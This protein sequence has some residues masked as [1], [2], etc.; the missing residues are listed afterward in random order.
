[1]VIS[2]ENKRK[3][4]TDF[5]SMWGRDFSV[6]AVQRWNE[7]SWEVSNFQTIWQEYHRGNLSSKWVV[8]MLSCFYK[9][10]N[11]IHGKKWL[12]KTNVNI[13]RVRKSTL[14][15]EL[16]SCDKIVDNGDTSSRQILGH[17]L[18]DKK[19]PSWFCFAFESRGRNYST[20]NSFV[21]SH[22]QNT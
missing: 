16:R 21:V 12:N 19:A 5:I 7:L 3:P 11:W 1:M 22:K 9:T 18:L 10:N 8:E 13:A 20:S 15:P 2:R 14:S 6:K 17:I 4:Q